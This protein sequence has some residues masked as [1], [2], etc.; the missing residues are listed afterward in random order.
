VP[1]HANTLLHPPVHNT[2]AKESFYDLTDKDMSGNEVSMSSFKGDVLCV[3]NVAS[4][5]GLT[6]SNYVQFSK[7]YDAYSG[8]GFKILA[9]PC[10]QFGAQEP[11]TDEEI[12]AFVDKNFSAKDKFTWF[13]KGHVNG[14]ET[15]EVYSFLKRKLPAEDGTTDIR[16]N[17]AKFLVDH[18]GTPFKR[19]GPKTN[20]EDMVK[21]IEELL[22][23]RNN[24]EK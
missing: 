4:K 1:F 7:L 22:A 20:P 5:W 2:I 3:V 16:W 14:K 18:E 9:F 19:Y 17:F 23:K 15:R 8:K 6:K 24:G 10:N 13:D 12:L 11:G 21:D